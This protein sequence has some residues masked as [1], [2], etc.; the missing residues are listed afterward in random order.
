MEI[1]SFN[2]CV[3]THLEG[4]DLPCAPDI[5]GES[6]TKEADPI[7]SSWAQQCISVH[8]S[9]KHQ[10]AIDAAVLM[11]VLHRETG[12]FQKVLDWHFQTYQAATS[13]TYTD[14]Q[15]PILSKQQNG[16]S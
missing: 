6:W 12:L 1:T 10:W 7:A 9:Q 4:S 8:P 16:H 5:S 2:L 15:Y 3:N 11:Q 13:H 14:Q